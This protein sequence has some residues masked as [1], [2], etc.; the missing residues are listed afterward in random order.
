[1]SVLS[2]LLVIWLSAIGYRLPAA[3]DERDTGRKPEAD[4]RTPSDAQ[5]L[6]FWGETRPLL[7]RLHVTI[8]GE[9]FRHVW[10]DYMS[11]V[12]DD[13]DSSGDGLL[14][15]EEVSRIP[16][17]VAGG[18]GFAATA[19]AFDP[20]RRQAADSQGRISRAAFL[21]YCERSASGPFRGQPGQ[22]RVRS[23]TALFALLD[24]NRD[25]K[26]SADELQSADASLQTRDFDDDEIISEQELAP[27]QSPFGQGVVVFNASPQDRL[28]RDSLIFIVEP[29]MQL[30]ETAAMLLLGRYKKTPMYSVAGVDPSRQ[31]QPAPK[32]PRQSITSQPPAQFPVSRDELKLAAGLLDELDTDNDGLLRE[33]ELAGFFGR[34][35]DVELWLAFGKETRDAD[36][37]EERGD[38]PDPDSAA[39]RVKKKLYGYNVEPPDAV[40]E[41]RLNTANPRMTQRQ[42]SQMQFQGFDPDNNGYI[43]KDEAKNNPFLMST[44]Q[45]MDRD[46][47]GKVFPKEFESYQDR[48]NEAAATRLVLEVADHGQPLF[49][50]LD[51]NGDGTLSVRELR[52]ADELLKTHDV[53]GDGVLG[54]AEIPRQMRLE[55]SRGTGRAVGG[56]VLLRPAGSRPPPARSQSGPLWFRKMDRNHDGDVSTR[57]FLGSREDFERLDANRD[58]LIDAKEAG[59]TTNDI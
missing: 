47:D 32:E 15:G 24:S 7:I 3:D 37:T 10:A 46:G 28:P 25:G 53:D 38:L 11:R 45:A 29:S 43:D 49:E 31:D 58:S 51:D 8:D 40:L 21:A 27:G 48:Q 13:A 17:Y 52:A 35:P 34:R 5:D 2:V 55:L 12:F 56:L 16:G 26:L 50:P 4:S 59:A 42:A 18:G 19:S 36:A 39:V 22:S 6:V 14:S 33:S 57:E 30:A 20:L 41:F 54:A 9:P 23:A 1:M 44:F